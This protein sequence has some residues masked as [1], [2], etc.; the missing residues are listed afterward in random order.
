MHGETI[1][2]QFAI[3]RSEMSVKRPTVCTVRAR[4]EKE[5]NVYG[6]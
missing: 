1:K 2:A 6:L 3:S 5:H 4:G